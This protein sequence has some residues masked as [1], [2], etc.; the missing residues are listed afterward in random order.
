VA[1]L[2]V[3]YGLHAGL[4]EGSERAV[5][6]EAST[7]GTAFGWY[8]LVSGAVALPAGLLVGGL[9]TEAGPAVAFGTAAALTLGAIPLLI[10]SG[11]R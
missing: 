4:T 3:A 6:A 10:G 11:E 8:N 2:F 5:V 9:W 1:A 7:S